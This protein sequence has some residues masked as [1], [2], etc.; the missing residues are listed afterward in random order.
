MTGK[1]RGVMPAVLIVSS[2]TAIPSVSFAA[3]IVNKQLA[4]YTEKLKADYEVKVF[5][6]DPNASLDAFPPGAPPLR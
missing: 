6:S 3:D 2:L 5:D 1:I 4:A